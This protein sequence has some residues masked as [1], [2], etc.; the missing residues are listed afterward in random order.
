GL[1][2][3]DSHGS[4]RITLGCE[5]TEEEMDYVINA[6]TESVKILRE[7]SPI[8]NSENKDWEDSECLCQSDEYCSLNNK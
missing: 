5:N 2:D 6:I 4:L 3:V 8:W 7:M 1:K